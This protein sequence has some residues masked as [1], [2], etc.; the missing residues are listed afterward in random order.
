[1]KNLRKSHNKYSFHLKEK[2]NSGDKHVL[3]FFFF[4]LTDL[5]WERKLKA[6]LLG[7]RKIFEKQNVK[8]MCTPYC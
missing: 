1:M 4:S 7:K 5:F 3:L 6:G 2:S 8:Q